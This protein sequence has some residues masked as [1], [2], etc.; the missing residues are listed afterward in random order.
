MD[1]DRPTAEIDGQNIGRELSKHAL[2]EN[3]T[4]VPQRFQVSHGMLLNVLASM[5]VM[6]NP[7]PWA[8]TLL[9]GCG[10]GP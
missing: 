8:Q 9:E 2:L 7:D 1:E 10:K 5:H 3:G 6:E 4:P